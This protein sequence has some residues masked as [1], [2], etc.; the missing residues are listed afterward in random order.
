MTV[1]ISTTAAIAGLDAILALANNGSIVVYD[2]AAPA[3]CEIAPT[4]TLLGTLALLPTA[5]PGS[6]DG[7]DKASA[8]ANTITDD[9]DAD[10]NG[11]PG[12]FRMLAS[13]GAVI[14]QGSAGG[15]TGGPFDLTFDKD[16]FIAGDTIGISAFTVSQPEV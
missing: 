16:S 5:F 10:A 12:Y 9:I 1:R 13:G 11:D 3:T 8:L 14:L 15:P 2:G 4:G 6:S 7:T